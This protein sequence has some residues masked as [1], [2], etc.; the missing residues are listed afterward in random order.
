MGDFILIPKRI[1]PGRPP[2]AKEILWK[3]GV[4]YKYVCYIC[5]FGGCLELFLTRPN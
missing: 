3:Q 5:L 4:N 2:Y 1:Q